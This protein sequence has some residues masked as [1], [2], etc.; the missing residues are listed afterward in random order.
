LVLFYGSSW[1]DLRQEW[2]HSTLPPPF[3][4]PLGM[5]FFAAGFVTILIR[6]APRR[7]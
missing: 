2:L 4:D 3:I 7:M 5:V 6:S 1:P